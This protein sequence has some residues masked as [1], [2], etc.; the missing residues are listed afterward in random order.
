MP[1]SYSVLCKHTWLWML[2]T[3]NINISVCLITGAVRKNTVTQSATDAEVTKH[4]I[5][6]FN[7]AADRATRRRVRPPSTQTE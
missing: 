4:A 7:L 5:R 3:I 1:I 2:H 6:W